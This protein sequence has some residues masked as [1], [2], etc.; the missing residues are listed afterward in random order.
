MP[1]PEQREIAALLYAGPGSVVTG[2][3]ALA[4]HWIR[5]DQTPQVDVLVP[6]RCFRRSDGFAALHRIRRM[7]EPTLIARGVDITMA[8]KIANSGALS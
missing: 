7:P 6:V 2:L 4:H 3:A 5:V 1:D 8:L